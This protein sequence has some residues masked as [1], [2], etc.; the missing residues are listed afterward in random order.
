MSAVI[1]LHD[2]RRWTCPHCGQ[3]H[4]LDHDLDDLSNLECDN[5]ERVTLGR[6]ITDG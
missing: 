4:V 5:C 3:E 2:P 1:V 6:L